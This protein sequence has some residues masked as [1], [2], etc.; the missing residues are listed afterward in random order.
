MIR[1][2]S[3]AIPKEAALKGGWGYGGVQLGELFWGA[4]GFNVA[5]VS[6]L[7]RDIGRT[8]AAPY[9]NNSTHSIKQL[10]QLH[11]RSQRPM[12]TER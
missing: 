7:L 3:K 8:A 4:N 10:K 9:R 1:S 11:D 12:H 5:G 6:S 2:E